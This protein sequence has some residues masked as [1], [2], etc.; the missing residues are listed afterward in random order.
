[1]MV[2]KTYRISPESANISLSECLNQITEILFRNVCYFAKGA[3]R[4]DTESIH[5][6]RVAT[7]KLF[8]VLKTFGPCFKKT[9]FKK[10]L[11]NVGMLLK[12]LGK[13]RD[14]DVFKEI[15]EK[16]S[17]D[18]KNVKTLI[19][20][21]SKKRVTALKHLKD[22]IA[23]LKKNHFKK[24]FCKLTSKSLIANSTIDIKTS[25]QESLENILPPIA[26]KM[27]INLKKAIKDESLVEELHKTRIKAKPLKSISEISVSLF[28]KTFENCF[29]EIKKVLSVMGEIHDLDET[30]LILKKYRK[31]K[32]YK[33][34]LTG[35]S[36]V[37][38]HRS[39]LF[40]QLSGI[41]EGFR[42]CMF[43]KRLSLAMQHKSSI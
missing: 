24:E 15:I 37:K 2:N 23:K 17:A 20:K 28:N 10:N 7:I 33:Y 39:A 5:D 29:G 9:T 32:W 25:L 31:K 30:L 41:V 42:E 26:E 18:T 1:M 12:S 21:F 27:I 6:M 43:V 16:Y 36:H 19:S 35:I 13:V 8:S 14:C 4:G 40:E 34:F 11:K 38:N 3:F 22:T